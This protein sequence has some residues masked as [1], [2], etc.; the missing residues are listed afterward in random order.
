MGPPKPEDVS[1]CGRYNR[2]HQPV[3]YL[4]D[5]IEGVKLEMP[6]AEYFQEYRLDLR[7][8]K[9]A[10]LATKDVPNLIGAAFLWAE[11][12]KVDGRPG[13]PDYAFSVMLAEFVR[14]A[15]FDGMVVRGVRGSEQGLAESMRQFDAA[16]GKRVANEV[17]I[18][19]RS[20]SHH[21]AEDS[22]KGLLH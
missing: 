4:A 13:R 10:D 9:L 7:S 5:S 20:V 6:A 21:D 17:P 19:D 3:L 1:Q 12:S 8:L 15:G 14:S 18:D 2:V 22:T 11:S 16:R